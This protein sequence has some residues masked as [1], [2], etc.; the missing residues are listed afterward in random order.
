MNARA[1]GRFIRIKKEA[2][3][4]FWPW[5]AVVAA[6][7][8]PMVFSHS[9]SA[10]KMDVLGFFFG[11]PLLATLSLGNEFYQRTFS[12]WL[13]Q[14][15]GRMQ[16]WGEKMSVM[17]AAVLSAGLITGMGMFF[18][19]LPEMNLTYNKAAAVA[20]VLITMAS[21]TYW[22]LAAR[23]TVGGFALIGCI[24]LLFYLFVGEIEGMPRPGGQFQ[25]DSPHAAAVIAIS[26][27]ALCFSALM[28]WLG[29]RKLTRFQVTGASSGEDLLVAGPSLMPEV[30]AEWVRCR[31]SGASFNL[32]RKELRILRP[33]WVIELVAVIYL[34]FL[35]IF[36]LLPSPGVLTP[37]TIFQWVLLGPPAMTCLGL[38]GLAGILSLGEEKRSGTQAW[39]VTLPISVRRQWLI[40][41]LTAM[42]AGL[43]CAVLFPVLTVMAGGSVYGSPFLFVDVP[44]VRAEL[45]VLPI[46]T[47]ACFWC[48]CAANGTV[49]A[50]VWAM[51]VIAAIPF[52]SAGGLWLGR[53]L[54]RTTG[55][56]KDFIVSMF[57]LSPLAFAAVTEYANTGILW[58]FIPT[59]LFALLQSY[60]LFRTP[61]QDSTL[62]ML[63]C[64][65]PMVAVTML[66]SFSAYAGF[67]ASRWEPFEET[68][69]AL[70]KLQPATA[71]IELTGEDLAKNSLL[72]APTRRWLKG[73]NIT[74]APAH[75]PLSAYF[76]TIHLASGLECRL[77]VTYYGSSAASCG[78]A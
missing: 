44:V 33:L 32:L 24:F 69:Q 51:P 58:L 40:K 77:T 13:T 76:A 23:S 1:N 61:P 52:A 48:A 9:S 29:A 16:L 20:Y 18:F 10:A 30:V 27:F 11:L 68:R 47:F 4:L 46:L 22:T 8:L 73:S 3:A 49:R 78:K 60:W 71:R 25:A 42:F 54:A 21:A 36:R 7:A 67:V 39:H 37:E 66:W 57:H 28:L 56:L 35:A 41:L 75:S 38:G 64:I 26:T 15:A 6:G 53:E 65:L 72:T 45:I 62:W 17:C 31:P 63:R 70:N 74:V 19:A 5:C 34:A 12:L 59:L 14:P 55:T 43:A 2:R 50:A